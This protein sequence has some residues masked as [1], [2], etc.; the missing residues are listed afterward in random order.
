MAQKEFMF[1]KRVFL[2]DTNAEGNVYFARYF[3]WQGMAR[4]DFFRNAVPDHMQILQSGTKLITVHAWLK[5]QKES[6]LFD[7]VLIKIRTLSIKKMSL[8]LGFN[9]VNKLTAETIAIGGQKLAFANHTGELIPVP[10]SIQA[11][12]ATCLVEEGSEEWHMS[13]VKRPATKIPTS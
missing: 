1:S 10:A 5:F 2:T 6:H 7:E 8:E 3:D 12:A 9:Y 13:L 11:G 4:E